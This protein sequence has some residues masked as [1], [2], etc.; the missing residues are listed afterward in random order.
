[1][2]MQDA[3][4]ILVEAELYHTYVVGGGGGVIAIII[5]KTQICELALKNSPP[6]PLHASQ[7]FNSIETKLNTQFVKLLRSKLLVPQ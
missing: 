4:C 7:R 2:Y 1:M 5:L 3:T 6:P